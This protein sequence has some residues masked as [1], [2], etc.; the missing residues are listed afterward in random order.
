[1]ISKHQIKSLANFI[2]ERF[3]TKKIFVF[4]S[5]A[6]GKAASDSDLDL[7]IVTE[8]G[9]R[10]KIDI[11]REIRQEIKS[12][13]HFPLDVLIYDDEEFSGRALHQNTL[14]HNISKHGILIH[15]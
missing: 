8:L 7:C 11:M 13:F 1:M 12:T 9:N 3:D 4:G 15:G 2:S 5:Y 10:R 6:H 14:E